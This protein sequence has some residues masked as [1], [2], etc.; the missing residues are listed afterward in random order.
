MRILYVI[1]YIAQLGGLDRVMTFKMNWL[2]QHGHEVHLVTYEQAD[3][4]FSFPL[5][6]R[7]QPTD[8]GVKLWKKKGNTILTRSW[9]YYKLRQLF[10][11]RMKAEL[12]R[13]APDVMVTLTDS[14]QV[15]DILLDLPTDA[16]RVVE[17]HVERWSF[18]KAGDFIGQRPLHLAAKLY[19]RRMAKY[20]GRAD[21]LVVLTRK[22]R[23]QWAEIS[24][25]EVIPNP[26]TYWPEQTASLNNK[27]VMAAG[28][29]HA[30]K[31]FDLLIRA[32]GMVHSQASDWKLHIYGDGPD[33]DALQHQIDEAGL[34]ECI[35]LL[36]ATPN[37]FDAYSEASIFCL[38]SRYEG[39]GLVLAE[40][41]ST[42]VPCVSFDCPHGP[43][44]II[45]NNEDGLLVPNKDCNALAKGILKYINDPE[46]RKNAG[47]AARRNI[48]RYSADNIMQSWLRLFHTS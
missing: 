3:H 43:A 39:Y 27:I 40:A 14:Y 17:S 1:K 31:G 36:P 34:S 47:A 20:I 33:R 16:K 22:D 35:S 26:L 13:I 12:N 4:E 7:I 15:L 38:S 25:V 28:R 6:E 32:W 45:T 37:I 19:D 11:Q 9:S 21:S 2:A 41:M 23:D 5:D 8:I 30:Q 10:K 42:G 24:N 48:V 18:M 46:L 44:D 29:L